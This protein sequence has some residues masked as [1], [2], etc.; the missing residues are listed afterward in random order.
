MGSMG[1]R[2]LTSAQICRQGGIERGAGAKQGVIALQTNAAPF[3][4]VK[5]DV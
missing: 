5:I 4:F 3:H 2:V 1:N